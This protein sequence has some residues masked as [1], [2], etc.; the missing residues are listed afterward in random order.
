LDAFD[1]SSNKS[2][3]D[4]NAQVTVVGVVSSP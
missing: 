3:R 2:S 1:A 4:P